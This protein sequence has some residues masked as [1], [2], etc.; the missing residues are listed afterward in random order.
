MK[1]VEKATNANT[2]RGKAAKSA[3]D[4]KNSKE[5]EALRDLA[6]DF[7]DKEYEEIDDIKSDLDSLRSNVVQL[8]R[9]LKHDGLETAAN[10]KERLKEGLEDLRVKGEESLHRAE[11][12]VRE[13][14]RNSVLLAFG[15]G[16]LASMLLRR[17]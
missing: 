10:V 12:K 4:I 14:P 1:Q 9:H 8:T 17:R 3:K 6:R 7:A 15:A 13:N 5:Y 16:V 11:D 2:V